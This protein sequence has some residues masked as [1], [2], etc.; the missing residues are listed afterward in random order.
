MGSMIPPRRIVNKK[1]RDRCIMGK[2]TSTRD[3]ELRLI[4]LAMVGCWCHAARAPSYR[5]V[6]PALEAFAGIALA[7]ISNT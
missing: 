6:I 7:W 5:A 4:A 3:L 2:E 1:D